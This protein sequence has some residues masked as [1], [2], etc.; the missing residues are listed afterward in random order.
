MLSAGLALELALREAARGLPDLPWT[1]IL[2]V[3]YYG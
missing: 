2:F 3:S 1:A